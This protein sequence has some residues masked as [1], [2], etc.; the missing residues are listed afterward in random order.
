MRLG[1]YFGMSPEFWINLQ[2]RY[3]LDVVDRTV[4]HKI[5]KEVTPR[6]AGDVVLSKQLRHGMSILTGYERWTSLAT[7]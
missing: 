2:S 4:R 1:R 5:E 6:N 7:C 3:D